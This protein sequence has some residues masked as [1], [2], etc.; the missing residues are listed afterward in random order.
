MESLLTAIDKIL[1]LAPE[2]QETLS[3]KT[4]IRHL[5]KKEILLKPNECIHSIY[6]IN[7]GLLRGFFYQKRKDITTWF[8]LEGEITTSISSLITGKPSLE[9]IEALEECELGEISRH[10]LNLLYESFPEFNK[11]GRLLMELYYI[12]SEERA[13]HFQFKT[14]KERYT[15]FLIKYSHSFHRIPLTHIASYLGITKET[16]SRIRS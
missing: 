15:Y 2:I 16:L 9:G 10:D 5:K 14:A 6:F 12:E 13:V 11:L 7:H 1:K 3:S 4:K 8:S